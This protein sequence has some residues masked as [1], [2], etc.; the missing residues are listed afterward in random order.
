MNSRLFSPRLSVYPVRVGIT[1]QQRYLEEEHTT[2]PD[3]GRPA[4]PGQDQFGDQRLH[5]K[6]Q[7]RAEQDSRGEQ[8]RGNPRPDAT[9]RPAFTD[10]QRFR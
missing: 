7:K 2:G 9:R 1:A 3:R 10:K 6:Q 5:L 4:E 8:R